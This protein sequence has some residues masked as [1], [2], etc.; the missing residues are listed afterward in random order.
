MMGQWSRDVPLCLYHASLCKDLWLFGI[1]FVSCCLF[2][3]R[4]FLRTSTGLPVPVNAIR[5]RDDFWFSMNLRIVLELVRLLHDPAIY[6]QW[7][8]IR[9]YYS[10]NTNYSLLITISLHVLHHQF[11]SHLLVVYCSSLTTQLFLSFH[12]S[13][14]RKTSLHHHVRTVR[15]LQ[16][17]R[18]IIECSAHEREKNQFNVEKLFHTYHNTRHAPIKRRKLSQLFIPRCD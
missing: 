16:L 7:R 3:V 15:C 1:I 2:R 18:G 8:T 10:T 9:S 6:T 14:R 13:G 17:R 11:T 5:S 12:V 4:K